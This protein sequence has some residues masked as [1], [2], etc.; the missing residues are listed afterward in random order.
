MKNNNHSFFYAAF[1]IL[2]SCL[3][4]AI[5]NGLVKKAAV[6]TDS[7]TIILFLQFFIGLILLLP[8]IFMGNPVSIKTKRLPLQIWRGFAGGAAAFCLF[9]AIKMISMTT[10]V[11]LVYAAPLWMTVIAYFFFKESINLRMWIGVVIGFVG[12]AFILNPSHNLMNIGTLI[13]I[14]GGILM[15]LA[16]LSV[17]MLKTTEP[18]RRIVFYYF[19][20]ST[21][22]SFPFFLEA[23]TQKSHAISL[24]GWLYIIGIGVSQALCQIFLVMAYHHETPAKLAPFIYSIIVFT[25]FIDYLFW[26]TTFST[27]DYIGT[28]LVIVGGTLVTLKTKN[29]LQ[30]N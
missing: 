21:L 11:L 24:I 22:M 23:I 13:A 16:F 20:V 3:F 30:E 12:V 15:A 27:F 9:L 2:I 10:A 25:A 19:L 7:V 1:L 6:I 29:T 26:G 28:F 5:I 18:T 17:R 14:L 4:S 8:M